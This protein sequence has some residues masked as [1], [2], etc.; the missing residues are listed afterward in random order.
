MHAKTNQKTNS[1]CE[2]RGHFFLN[3]ILD[4]KKRVSQCQYV[5]R[6]ESMMHLFRS[7]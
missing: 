3:A 6:N 4:L 7:R 5:H 2:A 1:T